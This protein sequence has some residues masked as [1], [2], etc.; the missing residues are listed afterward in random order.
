M[1]GIF[2]T[3]FLRG[4]KDVRQLSILSDQRQYLHIRDKALLELNLR[5][6]IKGILGNTVDATFKWSFSCNREVD[7]KDVSSI[8]HI[9]KVPY[10]VTQ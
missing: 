9:N 10:A 1:C 5:R 3:L 7:L 4:G 8:S 2:F 6:K